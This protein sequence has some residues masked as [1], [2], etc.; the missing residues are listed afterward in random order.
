MVQNKN[1][2]KKIRDKLRPP[3]TEHTTWYIQLNI[4]ERPTALSFQDLEII[5]QMTLSW[6]EWY[7]HERL[8]DSGLW[9]CPKGWTMIIEGWQQNMVSYSIYYDLLIASHLKRD[10]C[11][12][13]WGRGVEISYFAR[14]ICICSNFVSFLCLSNLKK[15]STSFGV[16]YFR[17]GIRFVFP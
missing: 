10:C 8:L 4:I 3:W 12:G 5:W 13:D 16:A 15:T 6:P 17:F 2:F 11:L 1:I 7:N 9:K 14:R